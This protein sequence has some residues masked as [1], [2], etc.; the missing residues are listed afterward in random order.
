MPTTRRATFATGLASLI[1]LG[2]ASG[3]AGCQADVRPALSPLGA[4]AIGCKDRAVVR[5]LHASGER[6]QRLADDH[7]ASGGCRVFSAASPVAG[8]R[9][10][11]GMVR[12]T[13]PA[14]GTTFWTMPP[15]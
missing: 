14:S 10:E 13:D 5:S 8:R 4:N 1:G 2:A 6:F 15:G 3:L 11:Q 12:F 9:V 7:L